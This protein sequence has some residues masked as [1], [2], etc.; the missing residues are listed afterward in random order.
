M[1]VKVLQDPT[2]RRRL[3]R[4]PIMQSRLDIDT[5]S[6]VSSLVSHK[7]GQSS[8]N[9]KVDLGVHQLGYL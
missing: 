7:K 2:I 4:L 9:E 6:H 5:P 8:W 1:D 3:K